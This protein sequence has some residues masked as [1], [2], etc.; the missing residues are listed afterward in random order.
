LPFNHL[1]SSGKVKSTYVTRGDLAVTD[2]F[3][4]GKLRERTQ[5]TG[6][7]QT[8]VIVD[9]TSVEYDETGLEGTVRAE[10]TVNGEHVRTMTS[11]NLWWDEDGFGHAVT[12]TQETG[13]S[14][15]RATGQ[16]DDLISAELREEHTRGTRLHNTINFRDKTG[17][18]TLYSLATG[19][20]I[21]DG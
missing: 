3:S 14:M 16:T 7:A 17:G 21:D 19:Y 6:D 1:L 12:T 15:G 9:K 20:R 5:V 4:K 18:R 8:G 10:R 2:Q 11:S 13:D